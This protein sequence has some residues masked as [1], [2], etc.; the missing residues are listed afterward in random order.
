LISIGAYPAGSNPVIDQAIMLRDP[1]NRF[2]RQGV[3]EGFAAAQSWSL[4]TQALTPPVP[5]KPQQRK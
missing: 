5:Q 2:L 1:L 4:L 3:T